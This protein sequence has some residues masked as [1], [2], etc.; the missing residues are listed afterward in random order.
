MHICAG[1][2]VQ[3]CVGKAGFDDSFVDIQ[4]NTPAGGGW[5]LSAVET[6][7]AGAAGLAP[8]E[9]FSVAGFLVWLVSTM[10]S[11]GCMVDTWTS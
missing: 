2:G 10:R 7:A 8:V 5:V 1:Q 4:V 6:V 3:I 9:P 11:M